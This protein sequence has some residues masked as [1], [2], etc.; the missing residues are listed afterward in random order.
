MDKTKLLLL[1]GISLAAIC[2]PA[3]AQDAAPQGSAA[4]DESDIIVTGTRITANGDNQPTPVT[5]AST[6]ALLKMSPSNIPDGLNKLPIFGLSRGT[7]NLNNPTDNFTGNYLNLR[8]FGINRNLVLLDGHRMAPTSY[9]GAVDI[10]TLPQMLVQRVEVVTGGASA[11]YGSDAVSGV[12]NFV[13]NKKFTGLKVEAQS[14]IASRGDAHS[15]RAGAAF[16]ANFADDRG[17]FMVSFDHFQQD[18]LDDKESRKNGR[19]IYAIAGGGTAADPFRLVSNARAAVIDFAG[20]YYQPDFLFGVNPAAFQNFG[21]TGLLEDPNFGTPQGGGLFSGGDGF[22]GKGSSAT[23][24]LKTDQAFARVDY[25]I[26]DGISFYAQGNYAKARTFNNFYPNLLFPGL[27]PINNAFIPAATQAAITAQYQPAVDAG[28]LPPGHFF[29]ARVFDSPEHALG[30]RAE[31]ESWM[32]AGG[33]NGKV[34]GLEWNLH[35]QHGVS[36]TVNTQV[37][38]VLLG[39]LAASLDAVDQGLASGG[40]A[41]GNIVCRV[42]VTNPTVYPG[43][44]PLNAFGASPASQSAA[45]DYITGDNNNVP[46]FTMDSVE[47]SLNGTAFENWA[48]PVRF[49]VTGEYRRLKLDVTTNSPSGVFADCTGLSP[50]L[51]TPGATA[52]FRD[53]QITPISKSENVKEGAIEID[54]PL[55]KDSGVG[56]LSL[57]AAARYTDYSISGSVTTWKVGGDWQIMDGLRLRATRSRDIRAPALYELFQ[58]LTNARSGYADLHTGTSGSG[59][60]ATETGGN[61]NLVP[62]KADTLTVGA[63]FKP[64]GVPGLSFAVDFYRIKMNNAITLVDGR[65]QAI[66]K[67]CEDSNGT[68]TFCSLYVRP[69]PFSDRTAANFPTLVK[70]TTLNASSVKTWGIDGEIN[71]S[72][73]VGSEGK[74]S[75]RGL[76]GYQP[77]L[78]T[79]FVPGSTPQLGAGA[80]ATQATGGVPKLRITAFLGYSNPN[81]SIDI[82]ERW[83]SSLKWNPDRTLVF[84]IPD[85]PAV[86]YTDITFTANVGEKKD[87]Q[88]FFSVQNLFDKNPPVYLT[89]GTSGTPAFSFP[90]TS[91]DDILGRYFTAGVRLKF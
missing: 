72:F 91:G 13:L 7:A 32:A 18:G 23:A 86:A 71:Y 54:F 64:A 76:V 88:I 8:G 12:V 45:L 22:Y 58:P 29:F 90:T 48:G 69:L 43:C 39:N 57:S 50:F 60:V 52:V 74:I 68:S 20:T 41:N 87:K 73:S 80:A 14:G 31:S 24:D 28:F 67:L 66:Q 1:A 56:S 4:E 79:I 11:V 19:G 36:K 84:D 47:A 10:N 65:Q 9:T 61:S 81:W 63:V 59:T 62:E 26:T 46:K 51:C 44:V 6:D 16:G 38:N 5:V 83:R 3:A 25:D 30:V 89:A 21:P 27:A 78:T 82:Q 35:Y 37:N 42:S 34:G 17:H 70:L 75:L 33:L 15:W 49:A 85:V 2:Q 40:T 77:Q 55:L 53:A